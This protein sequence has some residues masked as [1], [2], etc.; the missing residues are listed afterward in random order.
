MWD[1]WSV[2]RYD[3]QGKKMDSIKLPILDQL[4]LLLAIVICRHFILP[5]RVWDLVRNNYNKAL[6]LE[7]YLQ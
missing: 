2:N 3:P 1:G 6:C 5:Q 7:I 4:V